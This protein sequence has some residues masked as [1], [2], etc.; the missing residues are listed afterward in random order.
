[1]LYEAKIKHLHLAS[2][3]YN[4]VGRLNV[5]VNDA[6]MMSF[7]EG[8]RYEGCYLDR[9]G[10]GQPAVTQQVSNRFAPGQLHH[11]VWPLIGSFPIVE[12]GSDVG[13]TKGRNGAR[14]SQKTG[15]IMF[16]ECG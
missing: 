5:P 3:G 2:F 12:D 4:H 1:M 15:T 6:V 7:S 9:L 14:L 8:L 10:Q 13:V 16:I 11:Y